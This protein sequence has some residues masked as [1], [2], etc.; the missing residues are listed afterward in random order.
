MKRDGFY[1]GPVFV[2]L[3]I[4]AIIIFWVAS[5]MNWGEN[6][7]H[8]LLKIDGV[9]YYSYLPAIFIYQDLTFDFY[10]NI[11]SENPRPEL[12]VDFVTKTDIGKINKYYSGTAL[13]IMPFFLVSHFLTEITGHHADGYS[14]YYLL[15]IQFAAFFYLLMGLILLSSILKFYA[16]RN[17][18][19]AIIIVSILFGTNLFYYV[20]HEPFMSHIYSFAF[21]NLFVWAVLNYLK[22]SKA[23]WLL[24][25]AFAVGII[26]LIR[27]INIIIL[28]AVPFFVFDFKTLKNQ[29]ALMIRKPWILIL[30]I[31]IFMA[32]SFIQLIIYKIQTDS[33]IVYSYGK[34]GFDFTNLQIIEFLFSYRK[35]FFTWTPIAFISLFGLRFIFQKSKFQFFSWILFLLFVVYLLSSWWMWYYGGSFGSRVM[36]DYL[37]FFAIPLALL[38]Q[39]T[40]FRKLVIIVIIVVSLITQIQ[41]YQYVKGYIHWSEMNHEW[42]WENFLRI[43]KVWQEADKPWG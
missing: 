5:N 23:F 36:I 1:F 41:T 28:L 20:I 3:T 17:A 19:R 40:K 30:G 42:Y 7:W 33:F 32:I 24:I 34:E 26:F 29:F 37:V 21:V 31:L 11:K 25:S 43:D 12:D 6:R 14:Y 15:G 22:V 18:N 9:G 35:G 27:P 16:I 2:S 13:S 10:D 4:I 8:K 39:K 38:L